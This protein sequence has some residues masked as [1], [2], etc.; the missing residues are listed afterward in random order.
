[1][2]SGEKSDWLFYGFVRV[3][4]FYYVFDSPCLLCIGNDIYLLNISAKM[5]ANQFKNDTVKTYLNLSL[6]D[7]VVLKKTGY[8]VLKVS[9]FLLVFSSSCLELVLVLRRIQKASLRWFGCLPF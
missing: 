2:S 5:I 3:T 8:F 4:F 6:E 7:G 1:M 9:G